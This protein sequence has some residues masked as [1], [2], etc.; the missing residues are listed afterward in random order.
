MWEH[1]GGALIREGESVKHKLCNDEVLC[2]VML[3]IGGFPLS[4][5]IRCALWSSLYIGQGLPF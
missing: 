2:R 1:G 3:I 5:W 4:L